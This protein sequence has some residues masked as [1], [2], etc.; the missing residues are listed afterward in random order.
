MQ[1]TSTQPAPGRYP[2]KEDDM[3]W[4]DIVVTN[5]DGREIGTLE[6]IKND[7]PHLLETATIQAGLIESW[8]G[9]FI[10]APGENPD[11]DTPKCPV[12]WNGFVD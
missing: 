3:N 10:S 11:W 1:S 6:H 4:R 2:G 12:N 5:D 9:F 7:M 8:P